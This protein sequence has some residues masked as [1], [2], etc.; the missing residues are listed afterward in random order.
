MP[1]RSL[2]Q[3]GGG[4]ASLACESPDAEATGNAASAARPYTG[5]PT[6]PPRT[7]MP[8]LIVLASAFLAGTLLGAQPALN[9]A[10]ARELASPFAAA[11]VSL[12]VS[13]LCV[14]PF[15]LLVGGL[16]RLDGVAAAP[17]WIWT[18]GIAGAAVIVSGLIAAPL[19]GV[20]FFLVVLIA[21]QLSAGALIDHFGLFGMSARALDPTRVIGLVLVFSGVLVYRFGRG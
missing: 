19:V 11:L 7:P 16:P 13:V 4:A 18:G 8:P 9:A 5:L 21:G 6:V 2:P 14:L 3:T 20:A 17:W 1:R 10:L 15:A 12:A